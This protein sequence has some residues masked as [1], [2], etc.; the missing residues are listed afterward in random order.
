MKPKPKARKAKRVDP[1]CII[2]PTRMPVDGHFPS[3]S[4]FVKSDGYKQIYIQKVNRTYA[5]PGFWL[6]RS[7]ARLLARRILQ[8]L[9]DT[10][11]GK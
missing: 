11:C 8:A 1:Q 7:E 2:W 6:M 9:E 5:E 4:A 3:G 10:K